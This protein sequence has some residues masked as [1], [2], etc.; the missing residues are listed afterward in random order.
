MV[1][2]STALKVYSLEELQKV[3]QKFLR[4]MT[5]F[6]IDLQKTAINSEEVQSLT[7]LTQNCSQINVLKLKLP[8]EKQQ[9]GLRLWL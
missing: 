3:E 5:Y 6:E 8:K 7:M 1:Q 9:S 4:K 2:A